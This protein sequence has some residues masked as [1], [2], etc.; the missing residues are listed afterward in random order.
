MFDCNLQKYRKIVTS[1]K[2]K[3][4]VRTKYVPV[5]FVPNLN[6]PMSYIFRAQDDLQISS[7]RY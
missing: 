3:I 1:D 6:S 2:K 7:G 4:M 5:F